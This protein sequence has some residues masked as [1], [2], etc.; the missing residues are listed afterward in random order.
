MSNIPYYDN[1]YLSREHIDIFTK[2]HTPKRWITNQDEV[3]Q[4]FY[5]HNYQKVQVDNLDF[6]DQ[7]TIINNATKIITFLGANCENIAFTNNHTTFHILHA[8]NQSGWGNAY[9]YSNSLHKIQC[10][11]RDNSVIYNPSW[12]GND[13]LNG[14]YKVDIDILKQNL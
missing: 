12:G 2:N 10:S 13:N 9:N 6:W 8:S 4:V 3:T 14:P 7:V 5:Q 1:I 11:H